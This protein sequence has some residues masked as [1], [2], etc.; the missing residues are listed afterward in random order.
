VCVH[1]MLVCRNHS[2]ESTYPDLVI[3]RRLLHFAPS[4]YTSNFFLATPSTVMQ[5]VGF[6]RCSEGLSGRCCMG[7]CQRARF[8]VEIPNQRRRKKTIAGGTPTDLKPTQGSPKS[9]KVLC[10]PSNLSLSCT[11]PEPSPLHTNPPPRARQ[12]QSRV[13]PRPQPAPPI[14]QKAP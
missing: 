12:P 8:F 2:D 1:G 6:V 13:Q 14:Q 3:M 4:A 10:R 7:V 9:E 11:I 5:N